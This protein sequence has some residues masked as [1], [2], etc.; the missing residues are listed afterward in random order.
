MNSIAG[1]V[2]GLWSR[3]KTSLEGLSYVGMPNKSHKTPARM[4]DFNENVRAAPE[5]IE[6]AWQDFPGPIS[7]PHQFS[8]ERIDL[9]E[10]AF[11]RVWVT[12]Q[13]GIKQ[14]DTLSTTFKPWPEFHNAKQYRRD[15]VHSPHSIL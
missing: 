10:F 6:Q 2:V 11:M 15:K 12:D 14:K 4:P 7:L 13:S 3:E 5:Y 1:E 8:L 9:H